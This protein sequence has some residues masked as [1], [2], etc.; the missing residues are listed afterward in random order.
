MVKNCRNSYNIFY[1]VC[2]KFCVLA[3][4][5]TITETTKLYYKLYFGLEV[6]V[7]DWTPNVCCKTCETA[8]NSWWNGTRD[9]MPFAV[10]IIWKKNS[11]IIETTAIFV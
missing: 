1:Y 10:P 9:R 11:A 7:K 4:R 5:K 8:L 2:S 3:Q 6:T